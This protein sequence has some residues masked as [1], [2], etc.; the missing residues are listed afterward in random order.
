[1]ENTHQPNIKVIISLK[2]YKTLLNLN[3]LYFEVR[4]LTREPVD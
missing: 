2:K 3:T 4:Q 1:M